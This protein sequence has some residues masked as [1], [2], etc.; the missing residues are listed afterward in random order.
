MTT[1]EIQTYTV[2]NTNVYRAELMEEQ[3]IPT[4]FAKI[5][6]P[7]RRRE[8]ATVDAIIKQV[9]GATAF[10]DHAPDGSPRL[11]GVENPPFISVSH[12]GRFAVIA[13][14]QDTPIGIDIE[15]W[16]NSLM[17]IASRFLTAEQSSIYN[18]SR[19]LLSAWAM[20]EAIFKVANT[21]PGRTL[22]DMPLPISFESA[23]VIVDNNTIRLILLESSPETCLA[24]AIRK[25]SVCV[26]SC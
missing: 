19:R 18:S 2:D 14:N 3:S 15:H 25:N 16:R 10:I 5:K 7:S 13:T 22:I 1:L 11:K 26:K 23:E 8:T 6:A 24:L 20:K 12:S 21:I 4:A 9:F 17:K